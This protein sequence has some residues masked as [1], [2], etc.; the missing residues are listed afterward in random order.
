MVV[1]LWGNP[2]S[3]S[4]A[5]PGSSSARASLP[6]R[7]WARN[8]APATGVIVGMIGMTTVP[9]RCW[10]WSNRYVPVTPTGTVSRE[11]SRR[12][13]WSTRRRAAAG[14]T[15]AWAICS[16]IRKRPATASR[17]R[18]NGHRDLVRSANRGSSPRWCP[19]GP[20]GRPASVYRIEHGI[21]ADDVEVGVL[22]AGETRRGQ[23]LRGRRGPHRNRDVVAEGAVGTIDRIGDCGRHRRR[24]DHGAGSLGQL[25]ESA[26]LLRPGTG[27]VDDRAQLG[28][29]GDLLVG[30]RGD[31]EPWWH[32]KPR[33]DQLAEIGCFAPHHGQ[34]LRTETGEIEDQFLLDRTR[35]LHGGHYRTVAPL[36][37]KLN[38]R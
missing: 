7:A 24:E 2:R 22:L 3:T 6:A 21:R 4:S 20:Q 9:S 33:A 14:L 16:G 13:T 1:T 10:V 30:R 38:V 5:S 15:S 8:P 26:R 12:P 28:V 37:P 18:R 23:V 29:G 17:R 27:G 35:S 25:D 11:R 34:Q 32:P 31:A 36:R 19:V